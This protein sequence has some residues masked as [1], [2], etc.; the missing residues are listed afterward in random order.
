MH[1]LKEQNTFGH[2]EQQ[3]QV[4]NSVFTVRLS[5]MHILIVGL[6]LELS[7]HDTAIYVLHFQVSIGVELG[8]GRLANLLSHPLASRSCRSGIRLIRPPRARPCQKG[9]VLDCSSLDVVCDMS[10]PTWCGDARSCAIQFGRC[11]SSLSVGKGTSVTRN[12]LTGGPMGAN[13]VPNIPAHIE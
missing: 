11:A 1:A 9:P 8:K 2:V 7:S 5:H 3:I 12:C 6:W 10:A 13:G 4:I